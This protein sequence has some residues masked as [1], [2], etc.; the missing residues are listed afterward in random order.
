M[1][2]VP[3]PGGVA[4]HAV[5]DSDSQRP[6]KCDILVLLPD[7]AGLGRGSGRQGGQRGHL[8]A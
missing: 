5:G 6:G 7:Q 3:A 8:S 1:S 4:A 2:V